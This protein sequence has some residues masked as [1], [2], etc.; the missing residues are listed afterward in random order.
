MVR[1]NLQKLQGNNERG[2]GKMEETERGGLGETDG[3]VN[4]VGADV[5]MGGSGSVCIIQRTSDQIYHIGRYIT[6]LIE[7]G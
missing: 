7:R 4:V 2:E 3:P 5:T 1:T 6:L